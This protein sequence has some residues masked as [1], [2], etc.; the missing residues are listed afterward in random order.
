M[1]IVGILEAAI[2]YGLGL[3]FAVPDCPRLSSR[4]DKPPAAES[5]EPPKSTV[6]QPSAVSPVWHQA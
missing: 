3:A 5:S 1:T 2:T 4:A 6:N